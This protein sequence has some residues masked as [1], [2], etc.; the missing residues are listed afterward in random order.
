[1]VAAYN[2]DGSPLANR[3]VGRTPGTHTPLPD[4]ETVPDI[5]HYRRAL[6]RGELAVAVPKSIAPRTP[7]ETT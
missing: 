4:G 6:S 3:Y 1:M 5:E 7:K 2:A